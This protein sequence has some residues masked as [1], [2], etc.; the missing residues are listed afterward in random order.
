[1]FGKH[2]SEEQKKKWSESRKGKTQPKFQWLTPAGEIKIMSISQVHR[3]HPDWVL[4]E[5]N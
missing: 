2:H 4:Y 3:Y 5:Q 1:M